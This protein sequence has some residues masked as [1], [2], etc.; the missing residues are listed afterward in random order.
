[1]YLVLVHNH[2]YLIYSLIRVTNFNR[3]STAYDKESPSCL[4]QGNRH[5]FFSLGGI[6]FSVAVNRKFKI[7]H[8]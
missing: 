4:E 8:S 1:M 3:P 7:L 6:G 2:S 5:L